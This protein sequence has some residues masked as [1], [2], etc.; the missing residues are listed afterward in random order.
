[1]LPDLR[2]GVHAA[3]SVSG[4]A[5]SDTDLAR[6]L[7]T[8]SDNPTSLNSSNESSSP[9][10]RTRRGK[11]AGARSRQTKSMRLRASGLSIGYWNVRGLRSRALEVEKFIGRYD[12]LLLQE[13]R[14][15]ENIPFTL[16]EF[17]IYRTD[18]RLGLLTAVRRREGLA[19]RPIDCSRFC[20][21][22][23]LVSGITVEDSRFDEPVNV[24]NV[25]ITE[26]SSGD[27]WD[28]LSELAGLPGSTVVAGDYNARSP[29]WCCSGGW[30]PNGRAL[31]SNLDSCPLVLISRDNPTRLA[32]RRGDSDTTI[33]LALVSSDLAGPSSWCTGERGSSDHV[34]CNVHIGRNSLPL[35][36]PRR[37]RLYEANSCTGQIPAMLDEVRQMVI[38]VGRRGDGSTPRFA[39]LSSLFQRLHQTY[40]L[41]S[42]AQR[43]RHSHLRRRY[44]RSD[45]SA[46]SFRARSPH[47]ARTG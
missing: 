7:D 37:P 14:L 23:K 24:F 19:A 38:I 47:A 28:F 41:P 13:T 2:F 8:S 11:R 9:H 26:A 45:E 4:S 21:D 22:R 18:L 10:T 35:S 42:R 17:D 16:P 29:A 25:Y 12:V 33:D 27:D 5:T 32:E 34:I 39:H 20:D 40:R 30:N 36:R 44:A 31:S 15:N 3:D 6:N 43:C 1:M 46:R